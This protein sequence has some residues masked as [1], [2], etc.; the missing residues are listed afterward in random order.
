MLAVVH[1]K[2][3]VIY[4]KHLLSMREVRCVSAVMGLKWNFVWTLLSCLHNFVPEVCT[5]STAI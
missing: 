1:E 3:V 4:I 5:S 2:S